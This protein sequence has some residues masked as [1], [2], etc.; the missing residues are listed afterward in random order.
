MPGK[1]R[2]WIGRALR[3]AADYI[4]PQ[5][6]DFPEPPRIVPETRTEEKPKEEPRLNWDIPPHE[7]KYVLMQ[8]RQRKIRQVA[9]FK[10]TSGVPTN[11]EIIRLCRKKGV[12]DSLCLFS[13][14]PRRKSVRKLKVP[15]EPPFEDLPWK[16]QRRRIE[17]DWKIPLVGDPWS[18]TNFSSN[19]LSRKKAIGGKNRSSKP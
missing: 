1:V 6:E 13:M 17:D 10:G 8:Y 18:F 11:E 7:Q 15:E 2:K 5:G 16:I 3:T 14:R 12:W 9:I 19:D 4:E